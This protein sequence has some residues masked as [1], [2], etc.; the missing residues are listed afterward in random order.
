MNPLIF[1]GLASFFDMYVRINSHT[2][3][4]NTTCYYSNWAPTAVLVLGTLVVLYVRIKNGEP[5]C[6][7]LLYT[8]TSAFYLPLEMFVALPWLVKLACETDVYD[9]CVCLLHAR[10]NK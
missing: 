9:I 10:I 7:Q 8:C 1:D 4:C 2:T 5:C 6:S 3:S